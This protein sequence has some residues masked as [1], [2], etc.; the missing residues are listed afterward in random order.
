MHNTE[1]RYYNTRLAILAH[2]E[3]S[4]RSEFTNSM[5]GLLNL[6]IHLPRMMKWDDIRGCL[7]WCAYDFGESLN[8]KQF[9]KT[10]E[11]REFYEFASKVGFF[12][13]LHIEILVQF[14]KENRSE[15]ERP[16]SDEYKRRIDMI[17]E[18]AWVSRR[19]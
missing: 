9:S 3:F 13:A 4:N 12:D 16:H 15:S 2:K 14:G 19:G 17:E 6:S 5:K 7:T 18:V 10:E 11:V 8:E 1:R